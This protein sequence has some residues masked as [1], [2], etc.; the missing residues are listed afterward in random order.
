MGIAEEQ[1]DTLV[2][3]GHMYMDIHTNTWTYTHV[4][5]PLQRHDFT[6]HSWKFTLHPPRVD[7]T[8][9]QWRDFLDEPSANLKTCADCRE[10][11]PR[12]AGFSPCPIRLARAKACSCQP[13]LYP[14]PLDPCK[15]CL[16]PASRGAQAT[17]CLGF[18]FSL[19]LLLVFLARHKASSLWPS[20]P[21]WSLR[22][23]QKQQQVTTGSVCELTSSSSSS[24][25]FP[26]KET[27]N[28]PIGGCSR[29]REVGQLLAWCKGSWA[30]TG[31][32]SPGKACYVLLPCCSHWWDFSRG[33][34]ALQ[35]L[36]A[37]HHVQ[38]VPGGNQARAPFVG[39]SS[40]LSPP[41]QQ[42]LLDSMQ[43]SLS[44]KSKLASSPFASRITKFTG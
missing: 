40:P 13:R 16:L 6:S 24:A 35:Y 9:L 37:W 32:L 33:P 42:P 2:L 11:L 26:A 31:S 39:A 25:G 36:S 3:L 5:L 34:L 1:D 17:L 22:A 20:V 15:G 28:F 21:S 44:K 19:P 12:Q 8:L 30:F 27:W 4:G 29:S 43:S 7:F 38:H 10:Q 18:P 41:L 23:N 14:R